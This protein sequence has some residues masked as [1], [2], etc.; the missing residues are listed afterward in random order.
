MLYLNE[1]SF[2]NLKRISP[3]EVLYRETKIRRV[4][5][6]LKLQL[7]TSGSQE[8]WDIFN[9]WYDSVMPLQQLKGESVELSQR[10]T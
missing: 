9:Y 1:K 8:Y 7:I 10:P 6:I 3:K 5:A 2:Q 4:D